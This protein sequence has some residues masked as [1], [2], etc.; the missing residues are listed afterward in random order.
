MKKALIIYNPTSGNHSFPKQ[1]D[2]VSEVCHRFGYLPT[3]YRI[4]PEIDY[5]RVFEEINDYQILL[6][7]GGDGSVSR[8]VNRLMHSDCDLPLGIIPAGTANDFATALGLEKQPG[9]AVQRLLSGEVADVDIGSIND[10]YFINVASS[11]VL[12]TISQEVDNAIKSRLGVTGYYLKGMEH[13]WHTSSMKVRIEGE[14]FCIDEK[15]MLFL[16][17]NSPT[18]GSIRNVAPYAGITDGLLDVVV[19][20]ECSPAQ[21]VHV[22]LQA[23]EGRGAHLNSPLVEYHQTK[24]VKVTS[25]KDVETVIDGEW[26]PHMPLDIKVLPGRLKLMIPAVK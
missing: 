6:V 18:A 15:L 23:Y 7:S 14:G 21:L 13:L 4:G 10:Q 11:G 16:V 2:S 20:K 3:F 24:W 8:A 9:V 17:M 19:L 26:G 25:I 1:L 22:L 5:D 12:T